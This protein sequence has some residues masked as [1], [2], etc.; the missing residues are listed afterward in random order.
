METS[1]AA[2]KIFKTIDNIPQYLKYT[3]RNIPGQV[4]NRNELRQELD[5]MILQ[6][7]Q[8]I[9]G[10]HKNI[11]KTSWEI[12]KD[13]MYITKVKIYE[14]RQLTRQIITFIDRLETK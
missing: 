4:T 1:A 6:F 13:Y 7:G 9:N 12:A 14:R 8:L 11:K 10:L 5:C 3:L 2:Q